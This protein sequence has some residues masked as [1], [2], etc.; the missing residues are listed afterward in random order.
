MVSLPPLPRSTLSTLLPKI[1]SAAEPPL[2]VSMM[3]PTAM[4]MLLT[5]SSALLK[6]PGLRLIVAFVMNPDRSSVL[7]TPPLHSVTTGSLLTVKSKNGLI[8]PVSVVLNPKVTPP[9]CSCPEVGAP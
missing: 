5:L 2:A 9:A 3:V 1:R 8:G 4:A 6:V 7:L